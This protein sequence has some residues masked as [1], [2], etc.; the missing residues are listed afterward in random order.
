MPPELSDADIRRVAR[1]ARLAI[2]DSDLPAYRRDL[3][4]VIGHFE[5]LSRIDLSNTEP[6][7]AVGGGVN[8]LAE[9]QPGPTLSNE[10]LMR[11]ASQTMPPFVK[12]P[13]VL[14]DGGGA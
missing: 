2:P 12:V 7:A 10:V 5:R 6:M 3:S 14:E 9:D 4:A 13:K 8:R 11:L 1:L